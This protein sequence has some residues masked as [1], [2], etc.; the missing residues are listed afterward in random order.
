MEEKLF[1]GVTNEYFLYLKLAFTVLL[2][3]SNLKIMIRNRGD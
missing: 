1:G 2:A 3:A